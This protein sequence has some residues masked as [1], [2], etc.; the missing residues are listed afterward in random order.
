M[1]TRKERIQINRLPT[2]INKKDLIIESKFTTADPSVQSYTANIHTQK[3][4][5][6]TINLHMLYRY[7]KFTSKIGSL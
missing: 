4:N 2:F 6:N 7:I 3:D 1:R 5:P